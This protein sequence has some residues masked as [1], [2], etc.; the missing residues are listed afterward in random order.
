MIRAALPTV[1]LVVALFPFSASFA[2][3]ETTI[4]SFK[5]Y[6]SEDAALPYFRLCA[7]DGLLFGATPSGGAP[8]GNRVHGAVFKMTAAGFEKVLY[9]FKGGADGDTPF[10]GLIFMNGLLY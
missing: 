9:S 10:G 2:A 1:A 4:Y 3:K 8:T 6:A 7:A 5:G